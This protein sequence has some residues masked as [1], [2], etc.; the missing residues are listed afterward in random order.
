MKTISCQS[1][2]LPDRQHTSEDCLEVI[3]GRRAVSFVCGE[4]VGDGVQVTG[5]VLACALSDDC[6]H[7]LAA[8]GNGYVFRYEYRQPKQCAPSAVA[9][10]TAEVCNDDAMSDDSTDE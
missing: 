7:L 5:P 8:I 9:A 3:L 4:N 6:R 1:S 10:E 2:R